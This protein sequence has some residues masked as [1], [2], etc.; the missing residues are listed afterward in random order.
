MLSIELT[1]SSLSVVFDISHIYETGSR[2]VPRLSISQ[3][4]PMPIDSLWIYRHQ[5]AYQ[6]PKANKL[7]TTI[8][9]R[10]PESYPGEHL[11]RAHIIL[12]EPTGDATYE[13]LAFTIFYLSNK[14]S[15]LNTATWPGAIQLL[16]TCGV[17]H[18][19]V[20]LWESNNLTIR[21][22][23]ENLFNATVPLR[24]RHNLQN[25]WLKNSM[26]VLKWLLSCGYPPDSHI[27]VERI[28]S[29]AIT[30]LHAALYYH[31]FEFA[32]SLLDCGANPNLESPI[33]TQR[34]PL[35]AAVQEAKN[36]DYLCMEEDYYRDTAS[37]M[38][39]LLLQ[40]G[41]SAGIEEA[42]HVAIRM[43]FMDAI[44]VMI[45][46]GAKLDGIIGLS[47]GF[48]S[49]KG[50]LRDKWAAYEAYPIY[51]ETALSAA[52]SQGTPLTQKVLDILAV[53]YPERLV[54]SFVSPDAFVAAAFQGHTQTICLLYGACIDVNSISDSDGYC[55]INSP[56]LYG[57][58]PLHAAA[59]RGH[60][61]TCQMILRLHESCPSH[62]LGIASPLHLASNEGHRETVRLLLD[63]GADVNGVSLVKKAEDPWE[64]RLH[65]LI[66]GH[67]CDHLLL[68]PLQTIIN[69]VLDKS[70]RRRATAVLDCAAILVEN[71][72]KLTGNVVTQAATYSHLGL[73]TAALAAGGDPNECF[74]GKTALQLAL[75]VIEDSGLDAVGAASLLL[76]HGANLVVGD[77]VAAAVHGDWDLMNDLISRGGS[78]METDNRGTTVLEQHSS[79]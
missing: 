6:T 77:M 19:K 45:R 57:I 69:D 61:D 55:A 34:L 41:A 42:L 56:N 58:T 73:L 31:D 29:L 49:E 2:R 20:N 70:I 38:V 79:R 51:Q 16:Q 60:S 27:I 50:H 26:A 63:H 59:S 15:N 30:P 54:K 10:W 37:R 76:E 17:L 67:S 62:T 66:T 32:G 52:A 65:G 9:K 4:D 78:L 1:K 18:L 47:G 25:V 13:Y 71:G 48:S 68:A 8:A 36:G 40:H 35:V 64:S 7:A 74:D 39:E 33:G 28:H 14:I 43:Q 23:M 72:A 24:S 46:Y 75:K 22:F 44:D 53:R 12:G 5:S 11:Q 21:A 3:I